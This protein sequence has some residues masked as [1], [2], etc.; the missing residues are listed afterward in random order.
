VADEM[1]KRKHT[2]RVEIQTLKQT[3][4]KNT[5]N[6]TQLLEFYQLFGVAL[7][8]EDYIRLRE[9]RTEHIKKVLVEV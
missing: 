5:Q 3:T 9:E 8:S 6:L 7:S 4:D 2:L 1:K